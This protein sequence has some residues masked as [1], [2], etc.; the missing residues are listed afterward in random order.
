VGSEQAA[1]HTIEAKPSVRS[2]FGFI[3][4]VALT[5]Y[6]DTQG[7]SIEF[8][9]AICIRQYCLARATP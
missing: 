8:E 4:G 1:L 6:F 9:F 2:T 5:H 7:V 3:G